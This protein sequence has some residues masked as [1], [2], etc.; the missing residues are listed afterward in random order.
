M[1]N[2]VDT[3]MFA[4]DPDDRCVARRYGHVALD[5]SN[6]VGVAMQEV[7]LTHL[8]QL[9]HVERRQQQA[10]HQDHAH[11]TVQARQT[12]CLTSVWRMHITLSKTRL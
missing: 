8:M 1:E 4:K 5:D 7:L 9:V 10:D 12:T 6:G 3:H 11:E 2:K